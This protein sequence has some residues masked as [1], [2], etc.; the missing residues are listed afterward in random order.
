MVNNLNQ[1]HEDFDKEEDGENHFRPDV[2][3]QAKN[4]ITANSF[5]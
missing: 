5:T 1:Q 2:C 3:K 4:I